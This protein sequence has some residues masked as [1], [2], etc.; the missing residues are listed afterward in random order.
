VGK[1][2]RKDLD[3]RKIREGKEKEEERKE[4]G[5]FEIGK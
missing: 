2:R 1:L 5:R 4:K 3:K